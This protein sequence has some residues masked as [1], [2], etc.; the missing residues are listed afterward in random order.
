MPPGCMAT[1][2]HKYMKIMW[3]DVVV[4]ALIRFPG[5]EKTWCE[6]LG[7]FDARRFDVIQTA[8]H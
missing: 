8:R 3:F 4:L 6:Q 7:W 5:N 2:A 1:G